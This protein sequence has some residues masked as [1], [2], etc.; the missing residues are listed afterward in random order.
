MDG[1]SAWME[2]LYG[3]ME[4]PHFNIFSSVNSIN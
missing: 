2:V 1:G 3:W 4:V